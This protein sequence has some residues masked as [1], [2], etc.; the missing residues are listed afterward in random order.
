MSG[1]TDILKAVA[2]TIAT[3]LGGPLAGAAVSFLSSKLGVPADQV[4]QAVAGMSPADL[5][6]MKELDYDFQKF[7]LAN[8]QALNVGQME[9]NKVEAQSSSWFVAGWRPAAGWTCVMALWFTYV[10]K[11]IVMTGFW[12]YQTYI[13]LN[14]PEL[15]ISAAPPFPDLGVTDLIGLLMALLGLGG[16][17]SFEKVKGAEGNR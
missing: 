3:A 7:V 6:K 9:I 10:P 13:A 12:G 11:A 14:H 4:E 15:K 1:I 5:V 8:A 16:M 2:P 17:R